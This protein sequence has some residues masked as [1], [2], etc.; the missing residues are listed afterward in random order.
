MVFTNILERRKQ[1]GKEIEGGQ[2]GKAT[3]QQCV[4]DT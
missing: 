4:T 2:S 1:E 3:A